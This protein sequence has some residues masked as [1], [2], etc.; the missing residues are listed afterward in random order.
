MSAFINDIF[1]PV[2]IHIKEN[3]TGFHKFEVLWTPSILI[4]DPQAKERVR[5]EG[6]LPKDEF[7][8]WLEMSLARLAFVGK[9]WT[10][11]QER[12]NGVVHRFP[13]SAVAAYSVYWRGISSY[14]ETQDHRD[15]SAVT[16]EFKQKYQDSIWAKKA[17]VWGS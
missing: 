4:M 8:A 13:R 9:R 15:L 3:P 5:N 11:A 10:E 16:E 7:R 12:F 6:Y 1:V 14:K 2:E 17:M